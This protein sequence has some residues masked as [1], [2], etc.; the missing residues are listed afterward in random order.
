ML[1]IEPSLV[2]AQPQDLWRNVDLT[3]GK[4]LLVQLTVP[5]QPDQSKI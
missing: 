1:S 3:H 2:D 4:Y 5:K